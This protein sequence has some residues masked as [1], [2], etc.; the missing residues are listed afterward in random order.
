MRRLCLA[1]DGLT[2]LRDATASREVDLL[3]AATLAELAGV[4]AVRL[5]VT[6]DLRPVREEDVLTARR[7]ARRLELRLPPSQALLKVALEARPDRVILSGAGR[8]PGAPAAPLDLRGRSTPLEPVVRALAEAGLPAVA[9]IPPDTEVVKR[10]HGDGVPAIE[11]HTGGIVDLPASER[12]A[13][14]ERLADAVRLASKLQLGV[15]LA[16]GLAYHNLPELVATC[17]AAEWLAVGRAALARALLVGLDR[18]VR[19]LRAL[20]A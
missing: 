12:P 10:V 16:G 5:S 7:A 1:L 9:F 18:A 17:P 11:L 4:D 3:A 13:E 6:E 8:K 20:V 14:L 15:G 19:D 2:S